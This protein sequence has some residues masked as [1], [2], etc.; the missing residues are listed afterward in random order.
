[1]GCS[2][3]TSLK[4]ETR[5]SLIERILFVRVELW[6]VVVLLLFGCLFA[7]GLAAAAVDAARGDFRHGLLSQAALTVA[8]I[9]KNAKAMVQPDNRLR[10]PDS[11]RSGSAPSEWRFP[12]GP[13]TGPS[14]YLLLSRYDGDEKRQKLELLSLPT[15]RTVH[16]W[17]LDAEKLLEG[18]THV[19]PSAEQL[20]RTNST[21]REIHPLLEDNGD[22]IVKDFDSP[23]MRVDPCGKRLWMIQ[24]VVFHHSTEVDAEGNL[25]IPSLAN[26]SAIPGVT[27][28]FRDDTISAVSPSG[29][30]LLNRSVAQI[31][32]RHGYANWLFSNDMYQDD[33]THLNDIQPVLADGP[34][35]KK[36]DL[37][38]SLR[39]VSA[40]MLYRPATD[41]IIWM[42]RGPWVS[43][44]DVD[45]LDDHRIGVYDNGVEERARLRP[46]FAS[47]SQIMVYDFATDKVS[48]PLSKAM[49]KENIRSWVEGLFTEL[50]DGSTMIE[51]STDGR[52][53]I[54]H[55]TGIVAA[56]YLNRAKD[57]WLYHL[58][59]S[60]YID[61]TSGDAIVR[62]LNKARCNS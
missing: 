49:A 37:F 17:S 16:T 38:I 39:N 33:A 35:W 50:P 44:H 55:P 45:I 15:M 60:R 42:K 34:F 13:L 26:R 14:G 48:S 9:P 11:Y 10:V 12:S 7:I 22:L 18:I 21:F 19:S 58:G 40:I 46:Y 29:K 41:Q 28:K 4:D 30:L 25:W 1:M 52:L 57:G 47:S 62:Q 2:G 54:F 5:L 20:N 61:R 36:G 56:E 53:L 6:I 59:W 27:D 32:I 31:L 43:Q 24:E 51:A 23:L 8:E 3:D